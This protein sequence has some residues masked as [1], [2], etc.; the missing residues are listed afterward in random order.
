MATIKGFEVSGTIYDNEDT[1]ARESV[2]T[3]ESKNN[4]S[5]S[6]VDTGKKWIDGKTIYR[7]TISETV[8]LSGLVLAVNAS[9]IVS[10]SGSVYYSPENNWFAFPWASNT[11]IASAILNKSTN[12]VTVFTVG[13][14]SG[15][16]I[17]IEY[18]KL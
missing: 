16:K 15:C 17:T 18:T 10:V 11:S 7:K 5:T 3:L 1:Q 2:A 14:F 8:A 9:D 4:Y 6:E 12:Q 13:S